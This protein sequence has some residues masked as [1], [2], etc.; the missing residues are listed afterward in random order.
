MT[1]LCIFLFCVGLAAFERGT[2]CIVLLVVG[3]GVLFVGWLVDLRR[4]ENAEGARGRCGDR[5]VLSRS[6]RSPH[7]PY[8]THTEKLMRLLVQ[9]GTVRFSDDAFER[10]DLR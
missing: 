9:G 3:F 6:S 5:E 4:L 1:A 7:E 10:K 2:A 8:E